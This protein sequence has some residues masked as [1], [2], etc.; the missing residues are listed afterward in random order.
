M[1]WGVVVPS[2]RPERL[3]VFLEAWQPLF[4]RY[5]VALHV[6]RDEPPWEG[7]PD[8]IPRGSDMIR[9]W[10]FY[11]AWLDGCDPIVSLDDDTLPDP[12]VDLFSEYGRVFADGAVLSPYLSVGALTD[13]GRQMRGF[14]FHHRDLR[15]VAVQYGGWTGILDYDAETQLAG[16]PVEAAFHPVVMPVPRGAAVTGSAMN[17]AFRAVFTPL[18]WQFPLLDGQFD[19]YGDIWS[20]L[21]QKLVLDRLD[22]VMVVNG[23]ARV[24]HERASDPHRNLDKEAAGREGN[25]T[26]WGDIA[27]CF[28]DIEVGRRLDLITAYSYAADMFLQSPDFL[29]KRDGKPPEGYV[30]HFRHCL[31]KWLSLF[32]PS[33]SPATPKTSAGSTTA[34]PAGVSS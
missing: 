14:P 31:Q 12:D 27:D 4:H 9:S 6:V 18:M 10:G 11:Q 15:P 3:E 30:P 5:D 13:S 20:C 19:R 8:W 7:I 33:S 32:A 1:T 24:R 17:M 25:E 26:I 21:I 29:W 23:R 16:V 34:L 28:D 2:N 22:R